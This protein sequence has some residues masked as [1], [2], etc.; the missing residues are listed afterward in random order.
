MTMRQV[1]S[2]ERS[3]TRQSEFLQGEIVAAYLPGT[4]IDGLD[5][6]SVMLRNWTT[7]VCRVLTRVFGCGGPPKPI[8]RDPFCGDKQP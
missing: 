3:S 2:E 8:S 1:G 6:P 4:G 5:V 7:P